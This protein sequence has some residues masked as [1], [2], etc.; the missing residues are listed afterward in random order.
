MKSGILA[1]LCLLFL[2][3][4]TSPRQDQKPAFSVS[5]PNALIAVLDFR[6]KSRTIA[7]IRQVDMEKGELYGNSIILGDDKT[8][9]TPAYLLR[10]IPPGTYAITHT[11]T[12]SRQPYRTNV[13]C[14]VYKPAIEV[15]DVSSGKVSEVKVGHLKPGFTVAAP[16]LEKVLKSYPEITAPIQQAA[17]MG[18]LDT[19]SLPTDSCQSLRY[20][21]YKLKLL[22]IKPGTT[23]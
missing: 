9:R 22:K 17:L 21:T 12:T 7:V 23:A 16:D 10:E 8:S 5:N 1:V 15:F 11:I 19:K 2:S 4:C 14:R 18:L 13:L 20:D 6:I 3:A